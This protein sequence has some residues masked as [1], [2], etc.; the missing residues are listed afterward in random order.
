MEL[1]NSPSALR[2]RADS[3]KG[4]LSCYSSCNLLDKERSVPSG[5]ERDR[6]DY[7]SLKRLHISFGEACNIRCV[8]CNNPQNHRAN[9]I[10][11]DPRVV[12]RNVDLTPF[13]TIMLRGGEPLVLRQ[14]LEYM[15]YLEQVGKRYTIL[16]NGILI[17]DERAHR[18]AEHAHSVIVSLNGATKNGHESVN[19][20]SRFER[21]VENVQRMRRAR[22]SLGSEMILTGHMTITTSNLH[23]VPLF[24]RSFREFGFDRVNFG[25]VKET[26][27]LYLATHLEFA[28]KL[29]EETSAAVREVNEYDIDPLRLKLL[30]LWHDG[31]MGERSSSEVELPI[32]QVS[33]SFDH[34]VI[35]KNGE[36]PASQRVIG[37]PVLDVLRE[38]DRDSRVVAFIRHSERSRIPSPAGP[39]MDNVPLTP[40][41]A[42]LAR[43]FGR[44]LPDFGHTSV[45]HSSI[46]RS[47]QTATEIDAGFRESHPISK[48]ILV[49]KDPFFSVI[50]RGTIDK[51][52]RD[53]I[54]AGLRGQAFI[55]M[56]LDDRV[57]GTIMRPATETIARFLADVNAMLRKAPS[58]SIRIHVGHDREIESVRTALLGGRLSDYPMMDFLDG[59][60]FYSQ[61]EAPTLVRW[62]DRVVEV[63]FDSSPGLVVTTE[64]IGPKSAP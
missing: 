27:P 47:I 5:Y 43:R 36:G 18:L 15:D 37:D 26:V 58:G 16:T 4:E 20:G 39:S 23:E 48:M 49:G 60:V 55:E 61:G 57:P 24:L 51:K 6:I 45:S 17:D 56:W 59:L 22:D 19:R 13:D 54:R 28:E 1:I 52:S 11:L 25:Y 44:E 50:Y 46:I 62:R 2:L 7:S 53:A 42:E 33:P 8:M 9:P 35:A 30:G 3:L 38:I 41:G 12:I 34:V 32:V 64:D 40:W 31:G 29:K 10:L 21:V 14:C 63:T